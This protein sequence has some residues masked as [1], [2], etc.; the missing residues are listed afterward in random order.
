MALFSSRLPNFSSILAARFIMGFLHPA[1]LQ[2]GYILGEKDSL[3][4]SYFIFL[5]FI[6]FIILFLYVLFSFFILDL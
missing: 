5:I 2:A 6:I 4:F 3:Y 1:G